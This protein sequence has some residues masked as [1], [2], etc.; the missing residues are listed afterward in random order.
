MWRDHDLHTTY[1]SAYV[2]DNCYEGS[3]DNPA[4]AKIIGFWEPG[5]GISLFYDTVSTWPI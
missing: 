1:V 2:I 3:A 4:H 5:H